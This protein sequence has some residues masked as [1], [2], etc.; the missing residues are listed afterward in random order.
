MATLHT[1]ATNVHLTAEAVS[2]K[3]VLPQGAEL[4]A[5]GSV[6]FAIWAPAAET[7]RIEVDNFAQVIQLQ[8]RGDGW[9]ELVSKHVGRGSLYRYLLPDGTLVPD[10]A[11]R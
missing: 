4:T 8:A 10:P 6:R 5:D 2:R 3:H 1:N 9:H 7:M 11:S